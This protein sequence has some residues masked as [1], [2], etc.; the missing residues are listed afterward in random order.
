MSSITIRPLLGIDAHG[1]AGASA[2]PFW[3]S[4]TEIP[5]G[6]RTN[7]MRPSRGG[8]LMATPASIRRGQ[9]GVDIVDLVSEVAEVAAAGIVGF[10]PIVGELD[11]AAL[12]ARHAEE[13]EGVTARPHSPS[14]AAPRARAG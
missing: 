9:V 4:S 7:A 5:S 11:L 8:R 10:I 3:S 12:V 13:N 2:A 1:S 6:E 14:A